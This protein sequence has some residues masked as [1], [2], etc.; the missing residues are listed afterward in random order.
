MGFVMVQEHERSQMRLGYSD[1]LQGRKEIHKEIL[2]L[3]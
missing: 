3:G 2:D 1:C